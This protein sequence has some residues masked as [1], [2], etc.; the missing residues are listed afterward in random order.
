MLF[1]LSKIRTLQWLF[2]FLFRSSSPQQ[3]PSTQQSLAGTP[4]T[5][6]Q[7]SISKTFRGSIGSF[8]SGTN[9]VLHHKPHQRTNGEVKGGNRGDV[10]ME[11]FFQP[12]L[13]VFP[14]MDFY[15]SK[16][17]PC[18][19]NILKQIFSTFRHQ[20]LQYG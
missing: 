12:Y 20:E 18:S 15:P 14:F 10:Y 2:L 16:W 13:R 8:V 11:L 4:R 9:F 5:P 3:S 19:S 1:F 6:F 17:L 7:G